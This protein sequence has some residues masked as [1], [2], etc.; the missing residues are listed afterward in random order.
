MRKHNPTP[1]QI[2]EQALKEKI[3]ECHTQLK[4]IYGC[5]RV[6]VWLKKTFGLSVNHKRVYRLMKRAG[7]SC[8]Y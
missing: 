6:R 8:T 7:D 3:L 5:R 2:E 1:K 4:G